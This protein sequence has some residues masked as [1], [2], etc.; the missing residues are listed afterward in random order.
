VIWVIQYVF[1]GLMFAVT[2]S[3]YGT[4]SDISYL[5]AA[6]L[7]LPFMLAFY[8]LFRP[9]Q[10]T[11]TL[12]ALLVG[13]VGVL[14][15]VVAQIRLMIGQISLEQNMPPISLGTGL[16]GISILVSILLSRSNPQMPTGFVWLGM[17]SGLFLAVGG[18][19]GGVL[20]PKDIYLLVTGG[21]DWSNLNPLL[22]VFFVAAPISQLGYPV[23]A[24]WLGRLI[25]NNSILPPT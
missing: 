8:N 9:D 12:L 14:L 7:M 13:M 6:I 22:Y 11:A 5:L 24:I 20:L 17:V 21:L 2:V 25:L 15:I 16:I 23:W 18:I 19:L 3:P 10:P 4:L 1:L